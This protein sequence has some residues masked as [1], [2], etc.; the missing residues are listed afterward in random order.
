MKKFFSYSVFLVIF[1]C[2][3]ITILFGGIV[4]Y[5]YKDGKRFKTLRNISIFFAELPFNIRTIIQN[6]DVNLNKPPV[7]KKHKNNK[8]IEKFLENKRNALL[9]LPRYDHS[10]S[11]SEINV[12]DLGN[13]EIIHTYI[14]DLNKM[15]KKFKNKIT[16]DPIRFAYQHPLIFSDGSIITI[17]G[18]LYKID[19]C[20]NFLFAN[21][22]HTFHH[23]LELDHDNNIWVG[24]HLSKPYSKY[25]S[26]YEINKFIDDSI[27]QLSNEGKVLF[28]KSIIEILI[29]N[30]IIPDNFALNSLLSNNI[31]PIHLNDIQPALSDTLYWSKEDLFISIR[32]QSAIIHYRPSTNKVINYITGPFAEQHDVDIISDKEIS[33]FNNNNFL[34]KNEYSEIL[35]YNFETMKFTKLYHEQL[36]KD[37]F[38]TYSQGLSHIFK[39]GSLMVEEQNHGRII[40]YNNKGEKE[41]EY[42]NKD[43]N[44]NIGMINW[45]RII[46]DELIIEDFKLQVK[47]KKCSN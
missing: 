44:G 32:N 25:L 24:G 38:K 3:I 17:Y 42:I 1:L 26:K 30:K 20:S 34:T 45:S 22:E 35:I 31:D 5:H 29:E 43:K 36:K 9:V 2:F 4:S 12:I 37:E 40:L 10:L 23:S 14:V 41:W 13:F 11:K 27:I 21:E 16:E 15:N 8:K 7:L 28:E 6:K 33:I 46:E 39:D 19:F 47:N 18:K